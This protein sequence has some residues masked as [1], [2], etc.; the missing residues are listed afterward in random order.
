MRA[1]RKTPRLFCGWT[2][3]EVLTHNA[4][5]HRSEMLTDEAMATLVD[6]TTRLVVGYLR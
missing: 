3:I 6:E 5:L 4:V 1:G 2:S